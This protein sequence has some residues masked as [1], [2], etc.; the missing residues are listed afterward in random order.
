M[1]AG[2][3]YLAWFGEFYGLGIAEYFNEVKIYSGNVRNWLYYDHAAF[4]SF[5]GIVGVLFLNELRRKDRI[6]LKIVYLYHALLVL[7]IL[8]MGSRICLLIYVLTLLNLLVSWNLWKRFLI[9]FCIFMLYAAYIT[10]NID[11]IDASRHQL[12]A[13]SWEA[14]KERPLLGY[15]LGGA[16][17]VLKDTDLNRKVGF[18]VPS[19]FNH[20]HNQLIT[21]LLEIGAIGT[22][23]IILVICFFTVRHRQLN[24][25][26][27]F[28]FLMGLGYI[29]LTESIL[30]TSKPLYVIC[31][32]F[33]LLAQ[34]SQ[35]TEIKSV[36]G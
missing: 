2:I 6:N 22:L 11:K 34:D 10:S 18:M 25:R 14:I 15:G 5:F 23:G 7:A 21:T 17:L 20:A 16:E 26:N 28:L 1:S 31:F 30:Q 4:L 32:L 27:M 19:P 24:K 8:V 13:V 36:E 35:T 29:F 33:L 3:N 9:N 12:W